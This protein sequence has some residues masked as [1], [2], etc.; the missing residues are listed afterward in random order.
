MLIK[1]LIAEFL[2]YLELEHKYSQNTIKVYSIGLN[3]FYQCVGD[4]TFERLSKKHIENFRQKLISQTSLSV[5]SRN[6]KLSPLRSMIK[7]AN[8]KLDKP[9]PIDVELFQNRSQKEAFILPERDTLKAFFA[10]TNNQESD[11]VVYLIYATG[12]RISEIAKLKIGEVRETFS[13]LGKGNKQRMIV[14]D[15]TVVD[16]VRVFEIGRTPGDFLFRGGQHNIR[17]IIMLRSKINNV[18]I[19]PHT[20]R[21]LFATRLLDKGVDLRV[22]QELLGHS[23]IMTTQIYTHVSN[24]RLVESYNKAMN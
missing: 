19:K 10:E 17:K 23:S 1:N 6:L 20:L 22:V 2:R 21:H 9:N 12:M 13:I 5:K 8:K 11:L 18:Y 15:K 16:R 4:I 7:Y 24:Q 3:E 14:C